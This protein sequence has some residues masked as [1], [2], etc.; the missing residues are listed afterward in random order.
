MKEMTAD[1]KGFASTVLHGGLVVDNHYKLRREEK[2]TYHIS[3]EH[4]DD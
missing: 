1:L 2:N 3:N 4:G